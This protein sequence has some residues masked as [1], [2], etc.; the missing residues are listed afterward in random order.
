MENLGR[1]VFVCLFVLL[2]ACTC[3]EDN[4]PSVPTDGEVETGVD[5]ASDSDVSDSGLFDT[6]R[7]EAATDAKADSAT[8]AENKCRVCEGTCCAPLPVDGDIADGE[9][10]IVG[11]HLEPNG[12]IV[13][14]GIRSD[15]AHSF[16]E[17][18]YQND[19]WDIEPV[20]QRSTNEARVISR[21][22]TVRYVDTHEFVG[23]RL[24]PHTWRFHAI[25]D[26]VVASS[27]SGFVLD[28]GGRWVL[29]NGARST[30]FTYYIE[31]G[32]ENAP[33]FSFRS[34]QLGDVDL[35]STTLTVATGWD[36]DGK[37]EFYTTR[38]DGLWWLHQG[39][40]AWVFE[41]TTK[42][43]EK[44]TQ[45]TWGRDPAGKPIALYLLNGKLWFAEPTA[46]GWDNK[47]I[48]AALPGA[49]IGDV[50]L[51]FDRNGQPHVF[52]L[53]APTG[54]FPTD[55]VN[56]MYRD[57]D[58][59]KTGLPLADNLSTGYVEKVGYIG[60]D[61]GDRVHA[62]LEIAADQDTRIIRYASLELP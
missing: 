57:V 26:L 50:D 51:L 60:L 6:G 23:R 18:T 9:L 53:A 2:P 52:Y 3:Q 13:V 38:D 1:S 54:D 4:L 31:E 19:A 27:R 7:A 56:H 33:F 58:G 49:A 22:G 45:A 39:D 55:G 10:T 46:E 11:G 20:Q 37:V 36:K 16:F 32:N 8:D 44:I 59:W 48:E 35:S 29:P 25:D 62:V 28:T 14:F 15:V 41:Q 47:E 12:S 40:T 21:G 30:P 5:G 42:L 17:A 43:D 61:E 34:A 24:G